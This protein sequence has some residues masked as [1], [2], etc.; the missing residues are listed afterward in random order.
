VLRVEHHIIH[1]HDELHES[2]TPTP[3]QFTASEIMTELTCSEVSVPHPKH[4]VLVIHHFCASATSTPH[5]FRRRPAT[6][7][8]CKNTA[9]YFFCKMSSTWAVD[10]FP[11]HQLRRSSPWPPGRRHFACCCQ[12]GR[13]HLDL[14]FLPQLVACLL[15]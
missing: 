4:Y 7:P 14:F 2:A 15:S 11:Q 6:P 5:R 10:H 1:R 8:R 3:L 12:S 13:R 9:H